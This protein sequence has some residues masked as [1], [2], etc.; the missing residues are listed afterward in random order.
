MVPHHGSLCVSAGRSCQLML[1]QSRAEAAG[2]GLVHS[3]SCQSKT[4]H[5]VVQFSGFTFSSNKA[6]TL[7]VHAPLSCAVC[8]PQCKADFLAEGCVAT[9]SL[10][11]FGCVAET[12]TYSS[13]EESLGHCCAVTQQPAGN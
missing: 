3:F 4:W 13:A 10:I 11:F 2:M 12:H 6:E 9:L 7:H 8:R 1:A 5:A